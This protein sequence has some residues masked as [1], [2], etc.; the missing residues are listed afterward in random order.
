VRQQIHEPKSHSRAA[1]V[2]A[3]R[4]FPHREIADVE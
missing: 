1:R 2:M 3:M 4:P